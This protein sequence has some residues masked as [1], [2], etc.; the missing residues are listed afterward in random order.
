MDGVTAF[1]DGD[2]VCPADIT[3][4]SIPGGGC[5]IIP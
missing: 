2:P 3:V 1:A 4:E 5:Y